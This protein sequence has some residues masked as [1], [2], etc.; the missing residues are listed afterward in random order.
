MDAAEQYMLTGNSG[1]YLAPIIEIIALLS[2]NFA[3]EA[4]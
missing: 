1:R 4:V 3:G 2:G